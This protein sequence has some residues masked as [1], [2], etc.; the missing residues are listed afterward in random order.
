MAN[1]LAELMGGVGTKASERKEAGNVLIGG[2]WSQPYYAGSYLQAAKALVEK[3]HGSRQLELVA[4]PILYLQ[5]HTL[6]LVLKDLLHLMFELYDNDK[7]VERVTSVAPRVQPPPKNELDRSQGSHDLAALASDVRRTHARY[8]AG[9]YDLRPI[10]PKL[11]ALVAE[12]AALEK[13]DPTRLR[14]STVKVEDKTASKQASR[15]RPKVLA[16][17]FDSEV[18]IEVVRLQADLESLMEELQRPEDSLFF[19]LY[20]EARPQWEQIRDLELQKL[21]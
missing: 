18:M 2:I 1:S 8:C 14:Y 20:V 12:F 7:Y 10:S 19:D 13:N 15:K 9:G 21:L 3:A 5:R 17:S 16:R 4:V 11:D 6:E